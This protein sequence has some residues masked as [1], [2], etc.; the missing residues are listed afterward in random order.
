MNPWWLKPPA[1]EAP[2]KG[3]K[4]QEPTEVAEKKKKPQQQEKKS[5]SS[6]RRSGRGRGGRGR[7]GSTDKGQPKPSRQPRVDVFY[8]ADDI[9]QAM[10]SAAIESIDLGL[11]V[12]QLGRLGKVVTKRA[13]GDWQSLTAEVAAIRSAGFETVGPSD[14]NATGEGSME[15][16][17]TVDAME[18][19][20]AEG[21]SPIFVVIS[22]AGKFAP[23]VAKLKAM[24]A[25]VIGLGLRG[26]E[27]STLAGMCDDYF[28]YD[29]ISPPETAADLDMI[30]ESKAPVFALLVET[31]ESLQT[32]SESTLWGSTLK[33]AVVGKQPGFESSAYG[34]ATFT[35]LLEDA[36][37]HE[38]IQL[39]RDDRSG[40]YYV[41]GIVR[42]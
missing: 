37:R 41:A 8:D 40:G 2:S 16:H 20:S 25:R 29:E 39:E 19:C 22:G 36:E 13:Y 23:L 24:G 32:D 28:Y 14:D 1:D 10:R 3:K 26:S 21:S 5:P 7:R 38:V 27:S 31:I 12:E 42:K 33:K 18:L 4:P 15:V 6:Q 35:D 34:Y 30:D 11:I 17:L 9:A